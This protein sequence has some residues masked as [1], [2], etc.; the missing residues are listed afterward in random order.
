M[1]GC[2]SKER[3]LAGD[4]QA[5]KAGVEAV[6]AGAADGDSGELGRHGGLAVELG[7]EWGEAVGQRDQENEQG[8]PGEGEEEFGDGESFHGCLEM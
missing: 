2:R 1:V 4:V 8:S 3:R 7:L 5:G 6:E